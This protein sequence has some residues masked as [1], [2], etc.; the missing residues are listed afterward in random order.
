[1]PRQP[2]TPLAAEREGPADPRIDVR[3]QEG[4]GQ[5]AALDRAGPAVRKI[6]AEGGLDA[7]RIAPTG[8]GGRITKADVIAALARPVPAAQRRRRPP[9]SANARCGCA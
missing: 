5:P 1:M 8:P 7:A 2:L 4:E 9:P 6:V 3:E